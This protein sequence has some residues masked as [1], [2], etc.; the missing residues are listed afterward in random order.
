[1]HSFLGIFFFDIFDMKMFNFDVQIESF[2]PKIMENYISMIM[3]NHD[4]VIS[5]RKLNG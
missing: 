1:M 5:W 2:Y 3:R 4:T